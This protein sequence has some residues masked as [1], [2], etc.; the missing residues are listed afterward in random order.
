MI[1][2]LI[3]D[4]FMV[5]LKDIKTSRQKKEARKDTCYFRNNSSKIFLQLLAFINQK[6]PPSTLVF[7]SKLAH[8]GII[9]FF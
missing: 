6:T 1:I 2:T 4:K 8:L 5:I 3:V 7:L 9:C